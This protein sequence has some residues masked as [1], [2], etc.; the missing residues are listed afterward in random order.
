[1]FT[2][3]NHTMQCFASDR[4]LKQN[5]ATDDMEYS[6]ISMYYSLRRHSRRHRDSRQNR[7]EKNVHKP[8]FKRYLMFIHFPALHSY[9]SSA[10]TMSCG[11]C[12]ISLVIVIF[13]ILVVYNET[14]CF[15]W[16]DLVWYMTMEL[17]L[18]VEICI[19]GEEMWNSEEKKLHPCSSSAH[20]LA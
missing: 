17:Q 14:D 5:F 20:C 13:L 16:K 8:H 10:F 9:F 11:S 6:E 19:F 12:N 18:L 7:D 3:G 1:M 4:C 15:G 2:L